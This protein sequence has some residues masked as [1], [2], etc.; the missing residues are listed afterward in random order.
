MWEDI[1]GRT[2]DSSGNV[3]KASTATKYV[4]PALRARA[5]AAAGKDA[6]D[7]IVVAR[8]SKQV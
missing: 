6:A 8:L 2:R 5:E 4:P 1:Y 7:A 3:V